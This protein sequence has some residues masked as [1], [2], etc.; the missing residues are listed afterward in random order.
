MRMKFNKSSQLLLVSAASL[1]VASLVTACGTLTVDFVF[2]ASS[3]AAGTQQL[4]RDRRLR[5]QLRVRPD[6]PDSRL[7][8]SLGRTQPGG[9]SRL[10]RQRQPLCGQQDD[11]TIVQFIIGNDG[12]LYPQNTV[13]TPGVFPLAVAA[14]AIESCLWWTPTSRCPPAPPQR[15]APA[16]SPSFPS[17]AATEHM[18]ASAMRLGTPATNTSNGRQLLAADPARQAQRRDCAHRRQRPSASGSYVYVT[19]YDSS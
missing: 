7:A 19:A 10:L 8:L 18:L 9:R 4:R 17:G 14:N 6:A 13:N 15:P 3:K 2:V 1:L 11:N 16:P 12:K 5:G